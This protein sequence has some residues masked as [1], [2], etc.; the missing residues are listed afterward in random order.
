MTRRERRAY[1]STKGIAQVR[2]Q[3]MAWLH[4]EKQEDVFIQIAWASPADTE[5]L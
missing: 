3:C 5:R 4:D 2:R 1:R